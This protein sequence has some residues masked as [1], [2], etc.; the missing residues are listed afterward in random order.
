MHVLDAASKLQVQNCNLK[1]AIAGNDKSP[2][3]MQ[4]GCMQLVVCVMITCS[5]LCIHTYCRL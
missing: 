2:S 4:A 5:W 1:V 3:G